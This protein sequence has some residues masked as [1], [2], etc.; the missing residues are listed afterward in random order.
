M[1]EK[2]DFVIYYV[3]YTFGGAYKIYSLANKK[4]KATINLAQK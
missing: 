2:S 3:K 4:G 1:I